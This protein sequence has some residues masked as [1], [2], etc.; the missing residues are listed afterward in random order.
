MPDRHTLTESRVRALTAPKHGTLTIYDAEVRELAARLRPGGGVRWYV[1]VWAIGRQ[2]WVA[3]GAWPRLTVEQAREMARERLVQLAR[4]IDPTKEKRK[5]AAAAKAEA[6]GGRVPFQDAI[7]HLCGRMT[8]KGRSEPHTAERRRVAEAILAKGLRDLC[9][10]RAGVIAEK[11]IKAQTCGE[12]TKH[13]YGMHLRAIGRAA[14]KKYPDL[15]RD[16]FLALEVGSANI[17]APAMFDLPELMLLASDAATTTEWGRLFAFL[18]FTGCRLREGAYARWSRIDL[19]RRTFFVIPPNAEE[20]AA[21]EAVKRDRGRTVALQP[22]LVELL[23]T[24]PS[25]SD[26]DFLF[27]EACRTNAPITSQS[28]RAHLEVLK[29]Q[30]NGRHPH[31]LRHAHVTMSVACG[32][33]DMQLRL[34][35]GHGG[36]AMT[37]HYANAAMRWRGLLNSWN[38]TFHL[39]DPAEVKRLTDATGDARKV[40]G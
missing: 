38:G 29:I 23:R 40:A 10:P 20:K 8:T 25:T 14:L 39:R 12:L 33:P 28:F 31:S 27:P 15:I 6:R 11:W 7:D 3:L 32:V 21:G 37:A 24:W 1:I 13:R 36:P 34:S 22:E 18:L 19:D 5:A 16:P 17:P 35:V 2:R 30:L 9:D 26:D 4:G